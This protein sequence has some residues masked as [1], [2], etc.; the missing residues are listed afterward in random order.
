MKS[1]VHALRKP[2]LWLRITIQTKP[3]QAKGTDTAVSAGKACWSGAGEISNMLA[4]VSLADV[5][6]QPPAPAM[7]TGKDARAANDGCDCMALSMAARPYLATRD[8]R[9]FP[10]VL[11]WVD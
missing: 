10:C 1:P 9:T 7:L 8:C 6:T 11:F 2:V 4:A 3:Y 5:A